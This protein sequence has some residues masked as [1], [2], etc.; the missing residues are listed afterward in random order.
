[1]NSKNSVKHEAR[2]YLK[3]C[4]KNHILIK[5]SIQFLLVGKKQIGLEHLRSYIEIQIN[6]KLK[7][8][9]NDVTAKLV[10]EIDNDC[11]IKQ[12]SNKIWFCWLQGIEEAPKLVQKCYRNLLEFNKENEIILLTEKNMF[13][14]AAIPEYIINKWKDGKISNTHFSDSLRLALLTQHGGTWVDATVLYTSEKLNDII[15]QSELF[16]FQELKPGKYGHPLF[17]STWFIS[18]KSNNEIPLLT[19]N[20]LFEYLKEHNALIHYFLVHPFLLIAIVN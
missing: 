17:I 2:K 11:K 18:S 8:K 3:M 19:F 4:L 1:M 15:Y 13:E 20:L 14:Y 6:N 9:F 7:C 10:K 5:S 16:M 12:K